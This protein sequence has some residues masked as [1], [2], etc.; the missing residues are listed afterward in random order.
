MFSR[1]L[2]AL[3]LTSLATVLAVLPA[4]AAPPDRIVSRS[5]N[6]FL[7]AFAPDTGV[8]VNLFGNG[9]GSYTV[10]VGTA[11]A[12]Q[13]C[14]TV[15]AD[16]VQLDAENLSSATLGPVTV[17]LDRCDASGCQPAGEVTLALTFTGTGD[18]TTFRSRS[19][20]MNGCTF[21]TSSKGI[22]RQGTATLTIDGVTSE[23]VAFL[24]SSRDT[25]KV[26]CR[27]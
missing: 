15:A 9:D 5:T 18:L 3:L 17:P 21:T 25:F 6:V 23:T 13:G 26:Q 11:D 19:R 14:G 22:Q 16:A 4:A 8:F 1:R 24:S 2:I 27:N 7:S 10:C 20:S 12:F